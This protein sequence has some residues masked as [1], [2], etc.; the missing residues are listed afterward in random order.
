MFAPKVEDFELT[1]VERDSALWRKLLQHFERRL[2]MLR[3][4]NDKPVDERR[5]NV[6]R[7][8]IAELKHLISLNEPRKRVPPEDELFKD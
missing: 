6:L 4:R 8:Q 2:A 5:A 1:S 3:A 7:G